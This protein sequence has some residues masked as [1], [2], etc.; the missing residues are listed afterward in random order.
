[1]EHRQS[2]V[3]QN[4]FDYQL[5]NRLKKIVLALYLFLLRRDFKD[6]TS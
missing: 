3:E 6:G 5:Y 4:F 2:V 1:M